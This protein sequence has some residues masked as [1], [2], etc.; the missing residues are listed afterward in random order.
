MFN[1]TKSSCSGPLKDEKITHL[2]IRFP[3]P[4]CLYIPDGWVTVVIEG[5]PAYITHQMV[6]TDTIK[7]FPP[8]VKV[9]C[10]SRLKFDRWGRQ[11]YTFISISLPKHSLPNGFELK[12][13]NEDM[14]VIYCLKYINKFINIYKTVTNEYTISE[15][16]EKDITYYKVILYNATNKRYDIYSVFFPFGNHLKAG[17]EVF[18]FDNSVY[19]KIKQELVKDEDVPLVEE[20]I[21]NANTYYIEG[22]YNLAILFAAQAF[23][24]FCK[25]IIKENYLNNSTKT[26]NEIDNLLENCGLK[27]LLTHHFKEATNIDLSVTNEFVEWDKK[28]RPTRN[29]VAH[30]GKMKFK[31]EEVEEI[32][33]ILNRFFEFVNQNLSK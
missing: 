21:L 18:I 13:G 31:K 10:N 16:N 11:N 9:P 17:E 4:F 6:K 1:V 23:E 2:I 28:V 26:E 15:I 25:A 24:V 20:L 29:L 8:D 12:Y 7:G 19:E 32:F 27:N 33:D 5:K 3:L 22:K 30:G 14:F